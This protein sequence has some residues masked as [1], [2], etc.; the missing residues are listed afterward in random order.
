MSFKIKRDLTTT[1]GPA[2][3]QL[4][5]G[6]FAVNGITGV[7]YFKLVDGSIVKYNPTAVS[8]TLIPT[9]VFASVNE[10]CCNGDTL[11]ANITNLLPD[12][13]YTYELRNLN[14]NNVLF[15]S[16]E[17]G[18]LLPVGSSDRSISV[19]FSIS[20]TQPITLMKLSI[21]K[22]NVTIVENIVSICCQ[23]CNSSQESMLM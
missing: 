17:N 15:M 21:K 13:S 5:V 7:L 16:S 23:N 4:E 1:N 2:P 22:N 3:S 18:N 20:G 10:F 19:L 8:A 11:V 14:N 12:D 6:E 9:I